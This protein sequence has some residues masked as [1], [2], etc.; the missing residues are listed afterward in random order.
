MH[1]HPLVKQVDLNS[2]GIWEAD[3]NIVG[4]VHPEHFVGTA[5]FQI[6]PSYAV[7]NSL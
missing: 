7:L 3:G 1:Y 4:V 6:D 5:Y 2:I